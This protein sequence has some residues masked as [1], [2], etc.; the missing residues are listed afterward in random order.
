VSSMSS[1]RPAGSGDTWLARSSSSSVVSPIAET[2]T[3]TSCPSLLL[4][5]MRCATRL[6]AAAS[7]TEEPPYFWTIKPTPVLLPSAAAPV[8]A[9]VSLGDA[10]VGPG[11]VSNRGMCWQRVVRRRDTTMQA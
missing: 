7:E 1:S 10:L 11:S 5:T 4:A 2:T 3:T 8:L 9:W 6:T